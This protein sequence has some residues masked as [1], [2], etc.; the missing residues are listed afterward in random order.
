M[1]TT[2]LQIAVHHE[3][4]DLYIRGTTP[5]AFVDD[6]IKMLPGLSSDWRL[7]ASLRA[8]LPLLMEAAPRPFLEALELLLQEGSAL[9]PI[10]REG[11]FFSPFSPHT[12]LLWALEVLAWDPEHFARVSLILAKL[13]KLHPG[14]TLSNRPE[15]SLTEIF[16]P[17]HPSTNA[18]QEQRLAALNL[19]ARQVPEIGW[20]LITKLLQAMHNIGNYSERPKYRD[21]G[22]GLE[23]NN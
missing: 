9:R 14:G 19:I 17:W 23:N 20:T 11:G 6:L 5:Q 10:F 12:Y 4:A 15:N 1:A 2:L 13:A 22:A 18:S 21:A 7:I 3:G 16:L 8:E